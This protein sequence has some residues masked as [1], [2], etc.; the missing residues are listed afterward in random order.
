MAFRSL[1]AVYF[2]DLRLL[3]PRR[4][5]FSEFVGLGYEVSPKIPK[6]ED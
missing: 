2:P 4:A 1:A 3:L 6:I 5:D